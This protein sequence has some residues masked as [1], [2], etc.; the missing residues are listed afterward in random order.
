LTNAQKQNILFLK[1]Y[2]TF[3]VNL[4]KSVKRSFARYVELAV[5]NF[6]ADIENV[7]FLFRVLFNC[8][9][10]LYWYQLNHL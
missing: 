3:S 6:C 4:Q 2:Q 1:N 9:L 8:R 10:L 7:L 5:N